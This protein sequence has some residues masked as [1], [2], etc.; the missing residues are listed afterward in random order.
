MQ[1]LERGHIP[2][3]RRKIHWGPLLKNDRFMSRAAVERF[4]LALARRSDVIRVVQWL[5]VAVY[6]VLLVVP[7][8]LPAPGGKAR[9]WNNLR[10]FAQFVFWGLWWPGVILVTMLTGRTWCG[11][12]CPEGT[13]TEW[14]S[15]HGLGKPIPRWIRW[16]GWP[17]VAFVCITLYGQL[18]SVYDYPDAALL[19]LGGSSIAALAVG[20]IYG[21]GKRIWCR[22]LCPASGVFSLLTRLSPLHYRTDRAAWS[23][24]AKDRTTGRTIPIRAVDCPTL[25]DTSR[26]NS[27]AECHACGRCAGHRDAVSLSLR[28]PNQELVELASSTTRAH[29]FVLLFAVL[30]VSTAAFQWSISPWLLQL[31]MKLAA[32]LVDEGHYALLDSAPWWLLTNHPEANDVFT[33]LGGGLIVVYILG[34]GLLLGGLLALWPWFAAHLLR[35]AKLPWERLTMSFAPLGGISLMLGLT[36][37]TLFHVKAEHLSLSWVPGMRIALLA[38]GGAWTLWRSFALIRTSEATHTRRGIAALLMCAPIAVIG[39]LWYQAFFVW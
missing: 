35:D 13:L 31:K 32:R 22:Y 1:M 38:I 26:L 25:L 20:F 11:L 36:M 39:A 37:L 27:A 15:R 30:G 8:F 24:A 21:R 16:S 3:V 4:G 5:V 17:F 9:L 14:A 12:F 19:I 23:A 10:L 2:I 6:L 28:S 29:A 18:I 33:W 7:A 34:G